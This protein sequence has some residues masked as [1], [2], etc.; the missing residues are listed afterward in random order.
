MINKRQ[1]S[2]EVLHS[3]AH[4]VCTDF[5]V[6][7]HAFIDDTALDRWPWLNIS[8]CLPRQMHPMKVRLDSYQK[9]TQICIFGRQE[10]AV[11]STN[12]DI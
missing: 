8:L 9:G 1:F 4:N 3:D 7:Q 2:A 5:Y 6:V 10:L 11:L 12:Q